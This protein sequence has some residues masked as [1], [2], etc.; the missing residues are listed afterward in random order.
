VGTAAND[1]G[2]YYIIMFDGPILITGGSGQ[3]GGTAVRLAELQ[4][5]EVWAPS[6]TELNLKSASDIG[7]AVLRQPWAAVIN[8]AAYTSVDKAEFEPALAYAINAVAPA[9]LARETARAGIPLIHVSTDYVFD[10]N[11]RT[12]YIENDPVNPLGVY[13]RTKQ[14][15]EAAIR[16]VH[17][18]HGIIRTAWVVSSGNGNFID[19]MLRIGGERSEVRVVQDQIGCPTSAYDVAAALIKIASDLGNRSGTW[20]FVNSGKASWHALAEYVFAEAKRRGMRTPI[21]TPITTAEYPTPARRPSNSL[22]GTSAIER[23]FDIKPRQ[24][25]EAID[26]V[27]SERLC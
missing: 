6:R 13:G 19:T 4:G 10:G 16:T 14:A 21:L 23:D 27:L 12:Y 5:I 1:L 9:I 25:Q 3:I 22:L 11:K 20:H 15:G 8:C 2:A 17:P 26:A 24:W 7:K 18:N